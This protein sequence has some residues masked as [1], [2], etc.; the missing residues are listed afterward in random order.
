MEELTTKMLAKDGPAGADYFA[1]NALGKKLAEIFTNGKSVTVTCPNGTH[2]TA[3]IEGRVGRAITGLPVTMRPGGGSGCAFPDGETHVCP[4]EGTGEGVVVF[5]LTAHSVGALTQPIKVT[6]KNGMAVSIEGGDQAAAWREIF[7]KYGDPASFN[8]PAE[9]AIGL[10]PQVTPTGSMR[11]DKK[12]YA[13][14]HIGLGDTT[15]LGGTCKAKLRLEGVIRQP[16]ISVDG[17]VVVKGGKI[18][19]D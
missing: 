3:S 16:C 9:I 14:S 19:V 15:A 13:T 11:T 18:L 7:D 2:L 12:M 10:N 8:C 6:V 17:V 5:D 4:V 1:L